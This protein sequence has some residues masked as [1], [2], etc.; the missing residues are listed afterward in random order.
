MPPKTIFPQHGDPTFAKQIADL[1][2]FRMYATPPSS[3]MASVEEF[4]E[5]VRDACGGFEKALYQHM[6]QHYL[7]RRSPYRSLLLFHGLGVGK[8]CSSI[9]IAESFLLDHRQGMPPKILVV[10]PLALRRSYED[11]IFSI[12][13]FL[14][15]DQDRLRDQCTGD[16]YAKLVHGNPPKELFAR[17]VQALIRSRYQFI[18]YDSLVNYV[19]TNPKVRDM[20]IIV[21]EAHNLRNQEIEKKAADALE[22][23]LDNGEGN[24]LVLLS[25]TPM[26]NEPDEILWLIKLLLKNDKRKVPLPATL[27]KK[28]GSVDAKSAKLLQQ[29]SQEYISYIRGKNPFTFATRI[30]PRVN[31]IPT[32]TDEWAEP[33]E[34]GIVV[35]PIGSKQKDG[36]AVKDKDVKV[37]SSPKQ[38]QWLN[39]TYPAS[40]H[41]EK[42]FDKMF[43][44]MGEPFPV[45][46]RDAYANKLMPTPGNLD[47]VAA[48]LATICKQIEKA[49]GIVLIYSQFVWSGVVPLAI[50]LEHMGFRRFGSSDMLQRAS[51]VP[52]PVQYPGVSVPQYCILSGDAA[53]MGSSKIETLRHAINSSENIHGQKIKVV[54]ITPVASEGLSFQNVREVHVLDP[55]YHLNRLEQVIGRAIR[56]CSHTALPLDQRNVTVYLHACS[57]N[58]ESDTADIHAFK[59]AA[60][61]WKQTKEIERIIRDNA[62]D[63]AIHFHMNYLPKEVFKFDITMRS[64]QGKVFTHHYG[65]E[66]AAKPACG[67]I[68]EDASPGNRVTMRSEVYATVLPTAVRR[69]EKFIR[70]RLPDQ[71]Y[72]TFHDLY[73]A[74]RLRNEIVLDAIETIV[75]P[76]RWMPGYDCHFHRDGVVFVPQ[77]VLQPQREIQVPRSTNVVESNEEAS[78][79]STPVT[80]KAKTCDPEALLKS[81]PVSSDNVMTTILLY[82]FLDSSCW[83]EIAQYIV[84]NQTKASVRMYASLLESTGALIMKKELPKFVATTTNMDRFIGYVDIFNKDEFRVFLFD[85][86]E[87]R[88]RIASGSEV[89]AIQDKRT[90]WSKGADNELYGVMEP[91]KFSKDQDAPYRNIVKLFIPGPSATKR[92]GV[93]CSSNKKKDLQDWLKGLGHKQATDSDTKEQLCFSIALSLARAQQLLLYPE[94]KPS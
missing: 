89:R 83:D 27:F 32:I 93:V 62:M 25:A 72:F 44:R 74:T 24:R 18:T 90:Q 29:L 84:R 66:L 4:E 92:R 70:T 87:A 33:I 13:K 71:L 52:N 49:E 2:E 45:A 58:G 73:K 30:S 43:Q 8:T 75:H 76:A 63:C 9:T 57:G 1:E 55:W 28:D 15:G 34:D 16:V 10:S 7:S 86:K 54:L 68:G 85:E 50:A 31:G 69:M 3:Q 36:G 11:Q 19:A 26:Y 82:M 56:T 47:T 79:S 53:I 39:I 22:A 59:I 88:Y 37:G 64:S 61:K 17:R 12:A 5:R 60:R 65:D 6:M 41:G 91:F 80:T 21:D 77:Q 35:T 81:V 51:L 48:K 67:P 23:L 38:L 46:Y 40:T 94:W 14:E 42:G 20:V 78:S